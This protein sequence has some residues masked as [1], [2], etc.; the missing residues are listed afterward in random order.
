MGWW[1]ADFE[2]T[3]GQA[4]VTRHV[5][6]IMKRYGYGVHTYSY[7]GA[8]M[9]SMASALW[10]AIRLISA[11][12][13][14]RIK[15]LYLV[16]SRSNAGFVR[17]IPAYLVLLCGVRV[18]VHAHGSDIVELCRRPGIGLLAKAL[19]SRCEVIVPSSH[20]I[21]PLRGQGITKL[22]LCENFA[23]N[24]NDPSNN[25][26]QIARGQDLHTFKVLWNSN[27][28]ASKGFFAV[29]QAVS[30]LS[31]QGKRMQL[32]ALGEPLGDEVMNLAACKDAVSR[33]KNQEC[34]KLKGLVDRKTAFALLAEADF[35]CLPSK[36]SSEC[37]PLALIEAM[38]A[39]KMIL[40]ADTPA[41]R[42]T[43]GEYPCIVVKGSNADE[44]QLALQT[45]MVHPI[46]QKTLFD[47]SKK[48]KERFSQRRFEAE[49]SILLGMTSLLDDRAICFQKQHTRL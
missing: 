26:A 12:F 35:V 30:A 14:G 44:I 41:L 2:R 33:I 27:L 47:A 25:N 20:L 19:L 29:A 49:I 48:A 31:R 4:I 40:I 34:V 21:D 43:V 28:M 11:V 16:C 13:R 36:Y 32:I 45:S 24:T 5:V 7:R 1:G 3:T 9:Q 39:G 38:C 17:D 37:Q 42:A 46:D 6:G 8:G 18:L 23:H 10:S 22:H 15:T